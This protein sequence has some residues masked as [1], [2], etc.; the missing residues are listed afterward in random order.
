MRFYAC[1]I[2]V[3]RVPMALKL[4]FDIFLKYNPTINHLIEPLIRNNLKTSVGKNIPPSN[5]PKSRMYEFKTRILTRMYVL[6]ASMVSIWVDKRVRARNRAIHITR[7][8]C[9]LGRPTLRLGCQTLAHPK[10]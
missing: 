2:D 10:C 6:Y 5:Q 7:L 1:C 4:S 9:H 3:K 8:G